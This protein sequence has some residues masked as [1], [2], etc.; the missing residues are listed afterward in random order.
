M[1]EQ[2]DIQKYKNTCELLS[3]LTWSDCVLIIGKMKD[4]VLAASLTTHLNLWY[5]KD[6]MSQMKIKI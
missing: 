4:P 5:L 2:R 1:A 6:H 3:L